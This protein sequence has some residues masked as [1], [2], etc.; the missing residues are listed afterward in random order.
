MKGGRIFYKGEVMLPAALVDGNDIGM[1]VRL[2]GISQVEA[3]MF[4]K[5]LRGE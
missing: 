4:R 2:L 3:M 1:L 5:F